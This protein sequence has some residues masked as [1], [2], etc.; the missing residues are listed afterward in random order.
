MKNEIKVIGFYGRDNNLFIYNSY[1]D[2]FV[3]WANIDLSDLPFKCENATMR[4]AQMC[5]QIEGN[6]GEVQELNVSF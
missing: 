5:M 6:V 3:N 1:D 4:E 2:R